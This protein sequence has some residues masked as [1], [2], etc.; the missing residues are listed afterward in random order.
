MNVSQFVLQAS[1]TEAE[2]ILEAETHLVVT[3]EEYAWLCKLIDAPP[4]DLPELRELLRQKPV[5]DA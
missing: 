5:W 2:R 4:R 3:P 1:L